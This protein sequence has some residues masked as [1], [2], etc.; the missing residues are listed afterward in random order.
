MLKRVLG[1]SPSVTHLLVNRPDWPLPVRHKATLF[2][3]L[4]LCL[5]PF[6]ALSATTQLTPMM[7]EGSHLASGYAYLITGRFRTGLDH[8]PLAKQLAALPL[9]MVKRQVPPDIREWNHLS[10]WPDQLATP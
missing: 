9:L 2:A 6:Q 8:P 3:F 1:N 5:I 4:L 7:D 10:Q